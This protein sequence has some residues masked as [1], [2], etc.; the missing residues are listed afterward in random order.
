MHHGLTATKVG[1]IVRSREFC[2]GSW[3]LRY[4]DDEVSLAGRMFPGNFFV[5]RHFGSGD[6]VDMDKLAGYVWGL[7]G[8]AGCIPGMAL[9]CG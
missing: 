1:L 3:R 7:T 9:Y 6:D 5:D 4:L 8:K 2:E